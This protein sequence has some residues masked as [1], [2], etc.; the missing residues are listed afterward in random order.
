MFSKL[1]TVLHLVTELGVELD[2]AGPS[3]RVSH[4]LHLGQASFREISQEKEP[5]LTRPQTDFQMY[6]FRP[7]SKANFFEG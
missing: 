6:K 1:L 3:P 4:S 2:P 7:K 5:K